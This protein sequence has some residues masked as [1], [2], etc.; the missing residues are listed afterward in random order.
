MGFIYKITNKITGKCYIGETTADDPQKRWSAHI[1]TMKSNKGCPA[2]KDAMKKHGV[3]NFKFEVIIICFD[4]DVNRYEQEYIKKYNS[5]TPNGYNILAGGQCGG[6][7]KG[8]THTPETIAKIL[9]SQRKFREANPNHFE[10]YREKHKK[11]MEG[12]DFS[13]AVHKSERFQKAKKDGRIGVR[14]HKKINADGTM[15][16]ETRQK[17]SESLIQYYQEARDNDS[18][19]L[20]PFHNVN[21]E[22]HKEAIRKALGKPIIQYTKTGEVVREYETTE[23]AGRLSGVKRSNIQRALYKE[24]AT[25]GGFVW[26]FATKTA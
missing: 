17:I 15:A 12:I 4:E 14:C 18:N 23:D 16:D 11:S 6:G 8:K 10:T 5:M 19:L 22:K 13:E 26:R 9:E 20:S 7:F 21:R 25:A 2:L 24:G 1:H 3:E